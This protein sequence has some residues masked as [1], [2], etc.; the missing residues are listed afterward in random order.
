MEAKRVSSASKSRVHCL[1]GF[2]I[3]LTA[4]SVVTVL[5]TV[6]GSLISLSMAAMTLTF[7]NLIMSKVPEDW[8][9]VTKASRV[10][11][12]SDQTQTGSTLPHTICPTSAFGGSSINGWN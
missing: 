9:P 11:T 2:W 7:A 6:Y 3:N 1:L 12:N 8:R 4:V 5:R 10:P